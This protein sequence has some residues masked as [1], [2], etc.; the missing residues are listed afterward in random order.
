MPILARNLT[1]QDLPILSFFLGIT[2]NGSFQSSQSGPQRKRATISRTR[3]LLRFTLRPL[4]R[5]GSWISKGTNA[6]P[7]KMPNSVRHMNR[8][9]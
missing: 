4:V 3:G 5:L 1:L 8:N 2:M 9:Q 6:L 7:L